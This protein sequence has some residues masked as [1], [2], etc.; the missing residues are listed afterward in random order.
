[1]DLQVAGFNLRQC[2]IGAGVSIKGHVQRGL[3]SAG[4]MQPRRRHRAIPGLVLRLTLVHDA[5]AL[6]NPWV[7]HVGDR[8]TPLLH[9]LEI[10]AFGNGSFSQGPAFNCVEQ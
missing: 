1:M 5:M 4:R 9:I 3:I 6:M 2:E 8:W 7:I 10:L